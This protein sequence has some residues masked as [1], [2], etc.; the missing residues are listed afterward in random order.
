MKGKGEREREEMKE[1]QA[2]SDDDGAAQTNHSVHIK[3][4]EHRESGIREAA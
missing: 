3:V 1:N 2:L 4:H